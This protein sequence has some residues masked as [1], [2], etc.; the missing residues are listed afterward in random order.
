M[1]SHTFSSAFVKSVGPN[2]LS[3]FKV[4]NSEAADGYYNSHQG[5]ER[6]ASSNEGW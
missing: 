6:D 4:V 3:S 5:Y 2:Q 1:L